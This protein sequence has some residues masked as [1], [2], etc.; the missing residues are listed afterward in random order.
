MLIQK[1]RIRSLKQYTSD[2]DDGT[3]IVL[4]I[5]YSDD[6]LARA[7]KVGFDQ[8][9]TGLTALPSMVGPVTRRNSLGHSIPLRDEPKE[10]F[11]QYF[12]WSWTLF[13]GEE[14]TSM[15]EMERE[16]FKRKFFPPRSLEL[17]ICEDLEGRKF[18]ST[19]SFTLNKENEDDIIHAINVVLECFGSC[20]IRHSSLESI[21]KAEIVRLNWDLLPAGERPWDEL[22][23]TVQR[24]ISKRSGSRKR[25]SIEFRFKTLNDLKPDFTAVGRAGFSGYI[26]FG[27]SK[28]GLYVLESTQFDNATYILSEDWKAISGL[29]KAEIISEDLCEYRVVHRAS[30]PET[31]AKILSEHG[32]AAS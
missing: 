17:T 29:T 14:Q 10:K 11:Y 12:E 9:R 24:L 13:N 26:V 1:K 28:V 22:K 32:R 20:E 27:Y 8:I 15:V 31:V 2:I 25:Q 30:W 18:F 19:K 23:D 3:E 21:V 5:T 7:N 4:G 6:L 16:R